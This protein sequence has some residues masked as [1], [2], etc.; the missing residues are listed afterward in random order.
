[1]KDIWFKMPRIGRMFA[2]LLLLHSSLYALY[3]FTQLRGLG[4]CF[5][6]FGLIWSIMIISAI[7]FGEL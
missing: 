6:S 5:V 7:Y 3:F 4:V 1:M 2:L